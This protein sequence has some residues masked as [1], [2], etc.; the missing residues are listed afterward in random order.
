M[1]VEIWSDIACPW[2]YIGKRRFEVALARFEHAD[3]VTV[4]WRSFELD[5][6]APLERPGERAVHLAAKYGSSLEQARAMQQQMT[7]VAAAEGL[8]FRFDI[9][10]DGST[11]DAHRLLHFAAAH[12]RQDEL[13]EGLM[14]AYLSEGELMSDHATL[15]RLAA[16]AGLYAAAAREVLAGDAHVADVRADEQEAVALG[17]S[18]VPFF[19]VDRSIGTAGAQSPDALLELLR[20]GWEARPKLT[21]LST[22][23]ACGIDG[24]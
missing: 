12:G 6:E 19:V 8:D 3:D 23:D 21:V 13:K 7:D 18:A 22:G 15:A 14:R 9:A 10:R 20:R 5:P 17:I 2:C 1:H 11:F 16:E 24:C 4:T